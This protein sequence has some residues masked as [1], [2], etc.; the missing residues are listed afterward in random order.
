MKKAMTKT[1]TQALSVPTFTFSDDMNAT[2]LIKLRNE[3]KTKVPGGIS[4]LPF[5]IK[6]MSI[7]MADFPVLNSVVDPELGSDGLI[8]SYVIKANH[9]FSVAVDSKEGLTTPIIKNVNHKSIV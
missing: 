7:S 4:F 9:N 5:L 2:H 1:M 3:M 6:A 8:K